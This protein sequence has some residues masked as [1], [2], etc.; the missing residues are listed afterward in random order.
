M[1]FAITDVQM[2]QLCFHALELMKFNTTMNLTAVRDPLK[3]AVHHYLDSLAACC[4]PPPESRL[5]DIGSGGGFPGIPLKVMRPD[6]TVTLIDSSRK[7][8]TFLKHAIRTLQLKQMDARHVR[9]QELVNTGDS[10]RAFDVVISRALTSVKHFFEMALPL[11]HPQGSIIAWKGPAME[12]ELI[13]FR[14]HLDAAGIR[15]FSVDVV[16][17]QLPFSSSSRSL[18]VISFRPPRRHSADDSESVFKGD[19]PD[20]GVLQ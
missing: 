1:G 18:V 19:A 14:G 20:K 8:V 15:G 12:K 9:A 3:V 2:D 11:M 7:K 4:L 5:L 16:P 10:V 17:Y 6:L 13:E